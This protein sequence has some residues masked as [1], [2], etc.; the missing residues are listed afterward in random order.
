MKKSYC[1]LKISRRIC[2]GFA[3]IFTF[4]V[5]V[6]GEAAGQNVATIQ[7][8]PGSTGQLEVPIQELPDGGND[9]FV[10]YEGPDLTVVHY[11]N[12]GGL[13][14]ETDDSNNTAPSIQDIDNHGANSL[15]IPIFTYKD[16]DIE[17]P[18]SI[19]YTSSGYRPNVQTGI[20]GLGWTLNAGG[21]IER[22][23]RGAP[24]E[25][26]IVIDKA[27]GIHNYDADEKKGEIR[28]GEYR[29]I[30]LNGFASLSP[31]AIPDS[32]ER[33]IAEYVLRNHCS[34]VQTWP[35]IAPGNWGIIEEANM[36]VRGNGYW[37][38]DGHPLY[39]TDK[40]GHF[41]DQHSYYETTSDIYNFRYPG[42]SGNFVFQADAAK[43]RLLIR[44]SHKPFG[45]ISAEVF[46][47]KNNS[48][49][50]FWINDENGNTYRFGGDQE[51]EKHSLLYDIAI[52]Y[53]WGE[54]V[55]MH[56]YPWSGSDFMYPKSAKST[57]P[58]SSISTSN[59]NIT[60]NHHLMSS[61]DYV[62][63]I[64]PAKVK[65]DYQYT[66]ARDSIHYPQIT[67]L[68]FE[69]RLRYTSLLD[70]IAIKDKNNN[71]VLDIIF[72]YTDKTKEET[73]Y[74]YQ[75]NYQ[76]NS[77]N[78]LSSI[79]VYDKRV[80]PRKLIK[81]A[82]FNYEDAANGNPLTMLQ[83]VTILGE[84]SYNFEYYDPS[85]FPRH[86][87]TDIDYWG[88]YNGFNGENS[89]TNS[90]GNLNDGITTSQVPNFD[91]TMKGV[92]KSV[93]Y[94][95]G[96]ASLFEY[97]LN[98]FSAVVADNTNGNNSVVRCANY[99]GGGVR[100]K[101]ITEVSTVDI[102]SPVYDTLSYKRLLYE[103]NNRS[104][105]ISYFPPS[106]LEGERFQD[107]TAFGFAREAI[108]Y[109][110]ISEIMSDGSSTKYQY[111]SYSDTPDLRMAQKD[112]PNKAKYSK[113]AVPSSSATID[114]KSYS[115]ADRRGKL[116]SISKYNSSGVIVEKLENEYN[117]L[118]TMKWIEEI[119]F[120]KYYAYLNK[121]YYG[122]CHIEQSTLTTY[123]NGQPGLTTTTAYGYNEYGQNNRIETTY[124]ADN[125]KE[126]T[127]VEY[128]WENGTG[129]YYNLRKLPKSVTKT[130]K[131]DASDVV[132]DKTT[133]SYRS[134]SGFPK[135]SNVEKFLYILGSYS[136]TQVDDVS[137]DLY[138]NN[139]R[140]LQQTD[141]A[142]KR[143]AYIWGYN[144]QYPVA[145]IENAP[146]YSEIESLL[147]KRL[148]HSPIT[149]GL[150]IADK[151]RLYSMP[152]SLVTMYDYKPYIGVTQI[153]DPQG[154]KTTY[155]YYE[156]NDY[157]YGKL[158]DVIDEDGNILNTYI[159][160]QN[161]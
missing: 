5:G 69:E 52:N 65:D 107:N 7:G 24:D 62:L 53:P 158:K 16:D 99:P 140:L 25:V 143:T 41:T 96:G 55:Y 118:S 136:E 81:Q 72:S 94:P 42:N 98:D 10:I 11:F 144:G 116:L 34:P 121:L 92:L 109:T 104:S 86:G 4:I 59:S 14:R 135:L 13:E 31:W 145:I 48:S 139:G 78:K 15:T 129:S 68:L 70:T 89:Y 27:P 93:T 134:Y 126:I 111:T 12:P 155:R 38:E 79:T 46:H 103:H 114:S 63:N 75:Y 160:N 56:R 161:K 40:D 66:F 58:L 51:T 6:T 87:T 147:A 83:S 22:E 21:S 49:F 123:N 32:L 88:Y 85:G 29:T 74:G 33:G 153:I 101:S 8:L 19:Q 1:F 43:D 45:E 110:H 36:L 132:I 133:L 23:V 105:G 67:Q 9:P 73:R 97:E 37:F 76:I 120:N 2:L 108:E 60:F 119:Y 137:F 131:R 152:V 125:R 157:R 149:G 26:Q 71:Q 17:L 90:L 130:V 124:S 112:I 100:V 148:R 57:W 150:S 91:N 122:P 128:L 54:T 18:I 61:K 106:Y 138:D 84:G 142:G 80:S 95:T 30:Y 117:D 50:T 102:N 35:R 39:Y 82:I 115:R 77:P 156:T 47:N 141:R 127:D 64:T 146:E 44:D 20:L 154:R 159:Y 28:F 151:D 113:Y 3:L